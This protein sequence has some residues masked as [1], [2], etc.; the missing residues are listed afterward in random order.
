MKI[1]KYTISFVILFATIYSHMVSAIYYTIKS[2]PNPYHQTDV[3]YIVDPENILTSQ[4]TDIINQRLKQLETLTKI[5]TAV[6]ILPSIGNVDTREFANK[7]FNHWKIGKKEQNNGL[8]ILFVLDQREVVF[9]VGYGLEGNLTDAKSYRLMQQYMLPKFRLNQFSDGL[10][11]GADGIAQYLEQQYA[12]GTLYGIGYNIQ[13]FWIKT[14]VII[15]VLFSIATYCFIGDRIFKKKNSSK[16]PYESPLER[17][18]K[19]CYVSLAILP[20]SLLCVFF[21]DYSTGV[22]V[23]NTS[24]LLFFIVCIL[25][26][27][28]LKILNSPN[29]PNICEKCLKLTEIESDTNFPDMLNSKERY[30]YDIKSVTYSWYKCKNRKCQ[31]IRYQGIKKSYWEHCSSCKLIAMRLQRTTI[32]RAATQ[33]TSGNGIKIYKCIKCNKTMQ[34]PFTIN[35]NFPRRTEV[36]DKLSSDTDNNYN[37]YGTSSSFSS[38]EFRG[39]GGSG[40]GGARGKF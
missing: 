3:I 12:D 8:L 38:N 11:A 37:S 7:L 14:G 17:L 39:G 26:F 19:V 22:T 24:I 23:V 25:A 15:F 36:Y 1:L 29:R 30:Q 5:E 4:D 18:L 10:R 40:G 31:Y 16:K 28:V 35:A 33:F 32:V 6:V 13:P 34:V 2:I 20:L 27:I 21:V 9:E